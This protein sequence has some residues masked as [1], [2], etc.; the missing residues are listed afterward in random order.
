MN[1]PSIPKYLPNDL[2][3]ANFR[4]YESQL[5]AAVAAFPSETKLSVFERTAPTTFVARMR[6][7]TLSLKRF[8]W[9]STVDK[10][11]LDS[12]AGQ[13][14]IAFDTKV[15]PPEVWFRIKHRAGRPSHLL[16]ELPRSSVESTPT[17]VA[18][19]VWTAYTTEEVRSLCVLLHSSRLLGPVVLAGRVDISECNELE[20][21]YNVALTYDENK[22]Q[23]VVL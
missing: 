23:T 8:G 1:P 21:L 9:Y 5:A 17:L 15:S 7:A 3:E 20:I 14:T 12:I 13:Y 22:N 2:S 18:P 6:S 10:V 19:Q 4:R 16:N 11:K